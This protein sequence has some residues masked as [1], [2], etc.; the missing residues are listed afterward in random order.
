MKAAL[1]AIF[2]ICAVGAAAARHAGPEITLSDYQIYIAG[3]YSAFMAPFNA[4]S[5]LVGQGYTEA[6]HLNRVIFPANVVSKWNFPATPSPNGV[7][8]FNQLSYGSS[9]NGP[10]TAASIQVR[11]LG[12]LTAAHNLSMTGGVNNFDIIYDAFLTSTPYGANIDEFTV[13]VHTPA[14]SGAYAKS[15]KQ[16]GTF[17]GSGVTW[18]VSQASTGGQIIFMPA[19]GADELSATFDL[20]AM[21][22]YL[23]AEGAL[24]GNEYF[25][26]IALGVEPYMNG[27]ELVYNSWAVI[28][29]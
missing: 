28:E 6:I 8:G 11:N 17:V 26:G 18:A 1:L 13:M 12:T 15:L 5:L 25:N 2:A 19:N 20:K 24:T 27:G 23:I 4:G 10:Q 21:L 9:N 14:S 3:Q 7:Y 16:I 29:K 22:N